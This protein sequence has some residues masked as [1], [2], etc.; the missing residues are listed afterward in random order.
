MVN[1]IFR[2]LRRTVCLKSVCA[3]P[4]GRGAGAGCKPQ[5]LARMPGAVVWGSSGKGD[6]L[7][8][9]EL[10]GVCRAAR[11]PAHQ[12]RSR[13]DSALF[14]LQTKQ[15]GSALLP[16]SERWGWSRARISAR[17][18]FSFGEWEP[19]REWADVSVPLSL[20]S[21]C[22]MH[23]S[24]GEPG[25]PEHGNVRLR[26]AETPADICLGS[27]IKKDLVWMC[28]HRLSHGGCEMPHLMREIVLMKERAL[29]RQE[30]TCQGKKPGLEGDTQIAVGVG[31]CQHPLGPLMEMMN[32]GHTLL[33][34]SILLPA[35]GAGM[36]SRRWGAGMFQWHL[37]ASWKGDIVCL[38]CS[39]S[40]SHM[41]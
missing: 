8:L 37:W 33:R 5:H 26:L 11:V 34:L 13:W 15:R 23:L 27:Q 14:L 6:I 3:V 20:L 12:L 30:W 41:D 29:G 19:R 22:G 21:P 40:P 7:S 39:A 2:G 16:A 25:S 17:A 18:C 24:P 9:P 1:C 36:P 32:L 4:A 31:Y 38:L 35:Q 10:L 28:M